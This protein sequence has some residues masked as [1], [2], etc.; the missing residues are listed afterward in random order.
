M[1][2]SLATVLQ[3][4]SIRGNILDWNHS[5]VKY[6]LTGGVEVQSWMPTWWYILEEAIF[7]FEI[8]DKLF[9]DNATVKKHTR[10]HFG[11]KPFKCEV[12]DTMLCVSIEV[13]LKIHTG[14]EKTNIHLWGLQ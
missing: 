9:R 11:G 14:G 12:S 3:W 8:C 13:H 1:W 6:G 10:L 7:N 4:L 2:D 5:S